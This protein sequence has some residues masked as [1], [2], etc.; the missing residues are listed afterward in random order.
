MS[1]PE[2]RIGILE[3]APLS[4]SVDLGRVK[5]KEEEDVGEGRVDED[6]ESWWEGGKVEV[7]VGSSS[8][9]KSRVGSRGS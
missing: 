1:S 8:F 5:V 2:P 3:S 7:E 4:S 9:V 6:E